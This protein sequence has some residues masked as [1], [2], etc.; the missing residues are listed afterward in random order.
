MFTGL[1]RFGL[2]Q[3]WINQQ[4]C[5]KDRKQELYRNICYI[6]FN[7]V[8]FAITIQLL[9]CTLTAWI[10]FQ[11]LWRKLWKA[12]NSFVRQSVCPHVQT[13]LQLDGFLWNLILE[14][15]TKHCRENQN[16]VKTGKKC[17]GLYLEIQV[18]LYCWQQWEIFCSFS[19]T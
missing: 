9:L 11:A 14:I 1:L 17:W 4:D 19:I 3:P 5:W 16:L 18:C 10:N 6:Q 13:G 8:L 15:F 12:P 2:P 7:V